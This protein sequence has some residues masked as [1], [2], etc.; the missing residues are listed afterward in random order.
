MSSGRDGRHELQHCH[1]QAVPCWGNH[2]VSLNISFLIYKKKQTYFG[3]SLYQVRIKHSTCMLS[4]FSC[5]QLFATPRTLAC[6][7]PLPMG[8]SRQKYW[9]GLPCPSLGDLSDPWI[10][11][12][13]LT[14]PALAFRFSQ[15][16]TQFTQLESLSVVVTL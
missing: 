3:E 6:Q 9:S 16:T 5:V 15:L 7:A 4:R 10:E 11:P 8:F 2:I 13:Y 12:A 14:S 1:F